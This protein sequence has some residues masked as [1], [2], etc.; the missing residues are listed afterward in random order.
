MSTPVT[1]SVSQRAFERYDVDLQVEF[2]R[3][4]RIEGVTARAINVSRG[5]MFIETQ[6]PLKNGEKAFFRVQLHPS[7]LQFH[8][9]GEVVW[10]KK[11]KRGQNQTGGMGIRFLLGPGQSQKTLD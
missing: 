10:T 11:I 4:G 9:E 1:S 5:G 6:Q 8:L 3:P 7:S 2:K